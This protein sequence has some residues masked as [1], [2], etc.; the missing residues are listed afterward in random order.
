[1]ILFKPG[2]RWL[3]ENISEF[4]HQ[5]LLKWAN[6]TFLQIFASTC[7]PPCTPA[8]PNAWHAWTQCLW[9]FPVEQW[10]TSFLNLNF[11]NIHVKSCQFWLMIKSFR[12]PVIGSFH[13][14]QHVCRPYPTRDARVPTVHITFTQLSIPFRHVHHVL[15]AFHTCQDVTQKQLWFNPAQC[16][17]NYIEFCSFDFQ[18][19]ICRPKITSN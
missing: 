9:K 12:Q 11:I 3:Y 13:H 7:V 10:Y 15:V 16:A 6:I 17:W 4:L 1:M 14:A 2:L 18:A 5:Y 19:L 8:S